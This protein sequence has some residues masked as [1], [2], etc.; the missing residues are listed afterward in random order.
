MATNKDTFLES[1]VE[2]VCQVLELQN[3]DGELDLENAKVI[4]AAR[5][6]LSQLEAECRRP[7]RYEVYTYEFPNI[8]DIVDLV[9]TPVDTSKDIIVTFCG[10]VVDSENYT[11]V[12]N[13]I[14]FLNNFNFNAFTFGFDSED[15]LYKQMIQI[16]HTG[17]YKKASAES[18]L[19]DA[20]VMQ[21]MANYNRA[22]ITGLSSIGTA[23]R[24]SISEG[25][26]SPSNSGRLLDAVSQL[27]EPFIYYGGGARLL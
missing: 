6:A 21:T 16:T 25:T 15:E 20:L 27:V 11:V 19:E 3:S 1:V 23:G 14:T 24:G 18:T 17:G 22:A 12:G 7:F 26:I 2:A 8:E 5:M 9:I 4:V 10:Q 13:R